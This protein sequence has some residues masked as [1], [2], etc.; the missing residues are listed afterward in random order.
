MKLTF[1]FA[2]CAVDHL[3]CQPRQIFNRRHVVEHDRVMIGAELGQGGNH[4]GVTCI[5]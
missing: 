5:N 4:F 3:E 1:A 2:Q